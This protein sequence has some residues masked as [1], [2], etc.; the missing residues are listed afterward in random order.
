MLRTVNIH[1]TYPVGPTEVWNVLKGISRKSRRGFLSI[2][3]V[4]QRQVT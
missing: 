1:K 4:G 3:G 2:V